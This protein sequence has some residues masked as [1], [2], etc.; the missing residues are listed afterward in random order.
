LMTIQTI[1]KSPKAAP[2]TV[3]FNARQGR[4][5]Q[6][7]RY[8]RVDLLESGQKILPVK[9]PLITPRPSLDGRH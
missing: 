2:T 7:I 9:L 1:G 8:W 4:K 5:Y 6:A 3:E